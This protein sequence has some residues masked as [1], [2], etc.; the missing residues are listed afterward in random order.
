MVQVGCTINY[1]RTRLWKETKEIDD[2]GTATLGCPS[3]ADRPRVDYPRKVGEND[4]GCP[5]RMTP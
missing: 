4:K 5:A 1:G 2:V 3:S